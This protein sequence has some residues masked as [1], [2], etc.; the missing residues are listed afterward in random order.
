VADVAVLLEM[1]AQREVQERSAA[2]SQL[3]RRGKSALDDGQVAGR[4]VPVE[5]RN[6]GADFDALRCLERCRIDP[7]SGHGDHP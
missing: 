6:E 1:V 7:R 4:K 3:H 5:V 2:R